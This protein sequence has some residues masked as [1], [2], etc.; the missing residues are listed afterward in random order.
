M[1]CL[2]HILILECLCDLGGFAQNQVL[3][4]AKLA[5]HAKRR[6][7]RA[8]TIGSGDLPNISVP[9]KNLPEQSQFVYNISV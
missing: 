3:S 1:W 6:E 5:K 2:T 8:S 4:H 7:I 9:N